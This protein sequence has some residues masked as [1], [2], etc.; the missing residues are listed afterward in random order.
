MTTSAAFSPEQWQ[1]LQ[2]ASLWTFTAVA[3]ADGSVDEKEMRALA[4][5]L[6]EAMLFKEP[7]VREVLM[8]VVADLGGCLQA[9]RADKRDILKGLTE[10]A[11]LLDAKA[12]P[13]EAQ[14]FKRAMLLIGINV[15]KA[16]GGS[17]FG[18]FGNKVSDKEKAAL[19]L[20][21]MTLRTNLT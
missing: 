13:D 16:S 4:K 10:V 6:Q 2:F 8:A 7:L 3:G 18:L 20:V 21:A 15:A 17:F 1:T 14:G 5:E 19:A 12:A 9:F 11:D